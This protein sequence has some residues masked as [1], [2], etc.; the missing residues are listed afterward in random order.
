MMKASVKGIY[1][2][3]K[4]SA[5]GTVAF[6]ADVSFRFMNTV[7]VMEIPLSLTYVH[8]QGDNRTML[9]GTLV[10]DNANKVSANYMFGSG[11]CKLKYSYVHGGVR[12][13][14]P[15][16]DVSKNTWDFPMSQK[17]YGDDVF[18][19][20]YQTSSKNLG[21]EW[22]RNSKIN[23][24]F[25]CVSGEAYLFTILYGFCHLLFL[26]LYLLMFWYRF[27]FLADFGIINLADETKRPKLRA[28]TIW[29]FE[30]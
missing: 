15:C 27:L 23:G 6:N 24:T 11:N 30:M 28:E 13:F 2:T 16:Y 22:S 8:G 19:A 9:D 1:D 14:E 10:F 3:D 5:V 4:S 26:T 12:T 21:L 20:T 25:K 17:V 7:R 18:K 29:D